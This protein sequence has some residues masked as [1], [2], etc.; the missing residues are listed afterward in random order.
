MK[1][2]KQALLSGFVLDTRALSLFRMALGALCLYRVLY[3]LPYVPDFFSP[4]G[5]MPLPTLNQWP[6]RWSL[7]FINDSALWAGLL[8]LFMGFLSILLILGIKTKWVTPLLWLLF[9]S[10][11]NRAHPIEN[12]GMAVH[13]MVLF[14]AMFLPLARFWTFKNKFKDTP[15]KNNT[16]STGSSTKIRSWATA[17]FLLQLFMIYF[18]AGLTK[19]DA[20]WWQSFDAVWNALQQGNFVKP[21]GHFIASNVGLTKFFTVLTLFAELVLPF[22]LIFPFRNSLFRSVGMIGLAGLTFGFY[23][24]FMLGIFPFAMLV[25]LLG[26]IPSEFL[27]T[28]IFKKTETNEIIENQTFGNKKQTQWANAGLIVLILTT[29]WN[30]WHNT[31][32][33]NAPAKSK[34]TKQIMPQWLQGVINI[35]RIDQRWWMFTMDSWEDFW[36]DVDGQNADGESVIDPFA[37]YLGAKDTSFNLEKPKNY[38]KTLGTQLWNRF[39]YDIKDRNVT[40]E[41]FLYNLCAKY[42]AQHPKAKLKTLNLHQT[43]QQ[44]EKIGQRSAPESKILTTWDCD[45]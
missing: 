11:S 27:D 29:W 25:F 33:Y 15:N 12:G 5:F 30:N 22:T 28:F 9:V 24:T 39:T 43:T 14:W 35:P 17:G 6:E 3:L 21:I 4:S 20:G 19:D 18:Y 2:W 44:I 42:N 8:L 40:A 32:N 36:L 41:W 26:I 13:R 34:E 23:L 16:E 31:Y 45:A 38:Q 37:W 7:F 10:L 1:N